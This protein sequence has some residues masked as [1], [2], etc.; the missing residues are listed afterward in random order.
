MVPPGEP[1]GG[2]AVFGRL[3]A[4]LS[5]GPPSDT[6]IRVPSTAIL[7]RV[8][9]YLVGACASRKAISYVST[10][11]RHARPAC[12]GAGRGDRSLPR[13]ENLF[14]SIIKRGV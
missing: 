13:C 12:E 10:A 7:V 1:Y 11:M 2:D 5:R 4:E 9:I 6:L 8:V 3:C 14:R